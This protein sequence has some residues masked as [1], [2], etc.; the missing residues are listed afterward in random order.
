MNAGPNCCRWGL[1]KNLLHALSRV[2]LV[3]S[4]AGSGAPLG[5][6]R[7]GGCVRLRLLSPGTQPEAHQPDAL[8]KPFETRFPSLPQSSCFVRVKTDK[9]VGAMQGDGRRA[10]RQER[11]KRGSH[12]RSPCSWG[13]IRS[14]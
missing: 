4:S 10:H 3:A 5:S 7:L 2:M 13:W 12:P 8:I 6:P 1:N 11:E 14:P 9:T